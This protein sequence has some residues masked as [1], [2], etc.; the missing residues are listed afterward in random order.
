MP[1]LEAGVLIQG[2][3]WTEVW[4]ATECVQ[5]GCCA[6]L[7]QVR[8]RLALPLP[9]P[10]LISI[11]GLSIMLCAPAQYFLF[12]FTLYMPHFFLFPKPSLSQVPC[13]LVPLIFLLKSISSSNYFLF[14]FFEPLPI[15]SISQG[16]RCLIKN[17]DEVQAESGRCSCLPP[18]LCCLFNQ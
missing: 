15:A 14:H 12:C 18:G 8:P 13:F 1:T 4:L 16:A 11:L 17:L 3:H 5:L 10:V 2:S 7:C 9:F 6:I